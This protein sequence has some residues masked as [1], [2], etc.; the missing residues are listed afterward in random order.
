MFGRNAKFVRC[1]IDESYPP[2]IREHQRE[3]SFL[4]L[5]QEK[6][7]PKVL[8]KTKV[9]VKKTAHTLVVAIKRGG[10]RILG[11]H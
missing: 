3:L 10:R 9:F 6:G 11:M 7:L 5:Q 2:Y 1:E 4:I 8:R